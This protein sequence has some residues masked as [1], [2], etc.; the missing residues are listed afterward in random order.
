MNADARK[1]ALRMIPYG[2]HVLR[3]AAGRRDVCRLPPSLLSSVSAAKDLMAIATR[4]ARRNAMRSVPSTSL[5]DEDLNGG[6]DFRNFRKRS[7]GG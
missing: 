3:R 6:E 5:T 4:R 1:T 2:I 7:D